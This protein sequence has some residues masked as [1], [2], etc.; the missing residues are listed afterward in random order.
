MEVYIVIHILVFLSLVFEFKS[1]IKTK[2]NI[3]KLW[4]IF[5]TL[6]GGLR[7][8][9]GNDWDQYYEHFQRAEWNN[10]FNYDRYGNGRELLEPGFVFLNVLVKTIFGKYFF[11]NIL[12]TGFIQFSYYRFSTFVY[13]KR[14]L[15]VY[16]F[17]M[18]MA[19]N[20][21]AVRAGL[22]FGIILWAYMYMIRNDLKHYV[23]VLLLAFF[24]HNQCIVLFPLFWLN[25]V[26]LNFTFA[27][28]L[29]IIVAILSV[30]FQQ[31]FSMLTLVVGGDL[32]EKAAGYTEFQTEG[33]E[34]TGIGLMGI[35]LNYIFLCMY[36]YVQKKGSFY[37][38]GWYNNCVN[39]FLIY[40]SIFMVFSSG[41]GDL[42]RLS[43]MYF[44]S[45][46]VLLMYFIM[47][48]SGEMHNKDKIKERCS[49]KVKFLVY[50]F[51]ILYFV[52]KLP[53]NWSG[54]FFED[55][56]LPY[57]TIFDFTNVK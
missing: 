35:L 50:A 39:G 43:S 27:S 10:I 45:Q 30:K 7:W 33:L 1:S 31:M 48:F 2:Q 56:Y 11:F 9:I 36:Y 3:I 37:T 34:E 38:K 4:C 29:Y 46:V 18:N 20:Y 52:Y 15:L 57:T 49:K 5:F 23:L 16:A 13:P 19:S 44:P 26:R 32:G 25:K 42:A 14:P 21:F 53:G 51:F 6:F 41:M 22:C 17:L 40:I 8:G 54:P 28:L 55:A 12:V 47:Y 24:I